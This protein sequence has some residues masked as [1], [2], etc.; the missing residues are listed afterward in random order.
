MGNICISGTKSNM[1]HCQSLEEHV[2]GLV[3]FII[4]CYFLLLFYF[5]L[6]HCTVSQLLE[7]KSQQVPKATI[8]D[9]SRHQHSIPVAAFD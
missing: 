8:S 5:H 4:K 3:Q 1:G 2:V 7:F 6:A 9:T